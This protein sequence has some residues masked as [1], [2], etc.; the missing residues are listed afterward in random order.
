MHGKRYTGTIL[1]RFSAGTD[2]VGSL[3]ASG[4]DSPFATRIDLK[5]GLVE[6]REKTV[7]I[8]DIENLEKIYR[9]M[10]W[11]VGKR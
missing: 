9:N 1:V 8:T 5:R 2:C 3:V 11:D 6:K 10:E 4:V 7:C